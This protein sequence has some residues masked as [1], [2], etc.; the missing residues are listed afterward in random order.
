MTHILATMVQIKLNRKHQKR[1]MNVQR[2]NDLI[3][4]T[5]EIRR[6][7]IDAEGKERAVLKRLPDSQI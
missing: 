4:K 3:L 7:G 1:E 6:Q 5:M 2:P